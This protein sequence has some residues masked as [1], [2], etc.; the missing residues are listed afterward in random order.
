ELDIKDK[1]FFHEAVRQDILFHYTN[2]ADLGI[3][4]MEN[5]CLNHY[6]ALPNKIFEYIQAELPIICSNFPEMKKIVS[7]FNVGEVVESNDIS[8]I[9]QLINDIL[10]NDDKLNFYRRNCIIT[11][12]ILNWEN[13]KEIL[14]NIYERITT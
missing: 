13:E 1:V 2:S 7:D 9:A 11:K 3:H 10:S 14:L 12:D 6:Y 5:T 4:L 8:K